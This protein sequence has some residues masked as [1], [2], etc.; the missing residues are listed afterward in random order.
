MKRLVVVTLLLLVSCGSATATSSSESSETPTP[1]ATSLT[2]P[3]T[4][5]ISAPS[6][7]PTFDPPI[8]D[9]QAAFPAKL[10]LTTKD[11]EVVTFAP[12]DPMIVTPGVMDPTGKVVVSASTLGGRTMVEWHD[13]RTDDIFGTALV[14][15]DFRAT[16][17]AQDGKLVA[18]IGTTTRSTTV[19]LATPSRGEIRRWAFDAVVVPEAFANAFAPEGDGLPIGVF[20]IEYLAEHT[21]RVRVIDTATGE[22]G[23]PLNLRDKGQTVDEVMTAVSRTAV[24]EPVHQL[25]F[26]LYQDATEGGENLGAFIHTLGLINGV[27]CLDVPPELGLADHSGALAVSPDGSRLYAASSVGGVAGYVVDDITNGTSEMPEA[28]GTA[29]LAASSSRVA[30]GASNHEV[31]V[32]LGGRLFRLDPVTL[33]VRDSFTWDMDIEALTVLDDGS[34]VIVGTGRMT[35]VSRHDNIQAERPIGDLAEVTRVAVSG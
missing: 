33:E 32:A 3:Q 18:L 21:Y 24:F 29:A 31:V 17:V 7:S 30:I 19:V 26:T 13:V 34:I 27:W 22:L 15:G 16:A 11:G 28:R 14:D 1:E 10:A 8:V 4:S 2:T 23:L 12:H 9:S 20:V 35:L 25:L 6:S 5:P